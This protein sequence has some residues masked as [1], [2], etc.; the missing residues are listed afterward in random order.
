MRHGRCNSKRDLGRKG[1]A[2]KIM[3]TARYRVQTPIDSYRKTCRVARGGAR[4]ALGRRVPGVRPPLSRCS[5]LGASVPPEAPRGRMG[6]GLSPGSSHRCAKGVSRASPHTP[7][8]GSRRVVWAIASAG[9][10]PPW[11]VW[12]GW[13]LIPLDTAAPGARVVLTFPY[14]SPQLRAGI[15][16]RSGLSVTPAVWRD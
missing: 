6:G 14:P 11:F 16:G 12:H 9:W 7:V 2:D 4:P 15:G 1:N 8:H 3:Q 5:S 13:R 10:A